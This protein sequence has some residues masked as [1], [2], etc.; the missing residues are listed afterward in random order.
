[1][2]PNRGSCSQQRVLQPT[3]GLADGDKMYARAWSLRAKSLESFFVY[4]IICGLQLWQQ[5]AI[6]VQYLFAW[7]DR[8]RLAGGG[9]NTEH[10]AHG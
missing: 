1:M 8:P 4:S 6:S 9:I 5:G 2:M 7:Q 3:E 10:R